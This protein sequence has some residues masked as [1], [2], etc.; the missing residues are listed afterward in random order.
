MEDSKRSPYSASSSTVMIVDDAEENLMIMESIL[1]NEY[2]LKLF[3]KAKDAIEYAG[4]TPP[5][6]ILLI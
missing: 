4:G 1:A 2:S 6:L 3:D 5:D